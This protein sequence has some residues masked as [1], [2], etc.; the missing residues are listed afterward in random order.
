MNQKDYKK[1]AEI[2]KSVRFTEPDNPSQITTNGG[3]NAVSRLL[4]DY[5]EEEDRKF[6]HNYG[7]KDHLAKKFNKKQFLKDC[8]VKE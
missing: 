2:M 3:F 6:K 7:I 1:I 5:F 4:A 8:G